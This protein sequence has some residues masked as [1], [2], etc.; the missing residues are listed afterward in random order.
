MKAF[1]PAWLPG[2]LFY[3]GLVSVLL[4]CNMGV[5]WAGDVVWDQL[6]SNEQSV[7]S[8]F[9]E[10]WAGLPNQQQQ[11]LRQWAGLPKSRRAQIRSVHQQWQDLSASRRQAV[12]NQLDR[13]K[14]MPP[15]KRV[16]LRAWRVWV[17][18]LP[19]HEQDALHQ[20]LPGMS[21]AER[22]QYIRQLEEKYGGR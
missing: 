10:Q 17:K 20:R 6:S 21:P 3:A 7:L 12:M 13:Y 22:K 19:R 9:Q 2:R 18:S 15:A 1:P 14:N 4:T 11:V 16:K 8:P 5:V